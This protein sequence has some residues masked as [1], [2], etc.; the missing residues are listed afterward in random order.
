MIGALPTIFEYLNNIF[1]NRT[2]SGHGTILWSARSPDLSPNDF[3]LWG[4]IK[5]KI[6]RHVKYHNLEELRQK[7]VEAFLSITPNMLSNARNGFY[8]RLG[9]CLAQ[10]GDLFEQM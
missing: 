4:Y 3:F 6:Y 7:V 10:Q 9:Y 1:P 2:I 5:S 8:N